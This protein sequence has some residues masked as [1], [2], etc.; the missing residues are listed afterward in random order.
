M[1]RENCQKIKLLKLYELLCQETDEQ[2][3]L[4]TMNIVDR[5]AQMGISCERRTVAKDMAILNEQGYEVMARWVG[6]EKAYYVEDRS[7]SVPELKVLIDAVQ[8][9]SFITGKKTEELVDKIA[10]LGGSHRAEILKSN[11]VC[12]YYIRQL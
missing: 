5:L 6:K 3:P 9:A 2:H 8:A 12:F 11:M 7:F 10:S 1:E 4:T